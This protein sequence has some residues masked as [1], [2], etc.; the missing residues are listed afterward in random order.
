MYDNGLIKPLKPLYALSVILKRVL[1][2]IAATARSRYL[3]CELITLQTLTDIIQFKFD[4]E[5]SI[6]FKCLK[7]AV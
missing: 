3:S 2:L 6:V 1:L 4:F 7:H 5:I